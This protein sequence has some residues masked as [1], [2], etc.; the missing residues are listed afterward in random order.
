MKDRYGIYGPNCVIYLGFIKR[1]TIFMTVCILAYAVPMLI[2]NL[3]GVICRDSSTAC[4]AQDVIYFW[5]TYN[6]LGA[7]PGSLPHH[8]LWFVFS[9]TIIVFLLYL[10]KYSLKTFRIVNGKN[11]TDS[12]FALILRRLPE[13]TT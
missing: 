8:I 2:L 3:S 13:G 5:S 4:N 10:R 1:I 9:L 11:I 12:D 6:V 7:T